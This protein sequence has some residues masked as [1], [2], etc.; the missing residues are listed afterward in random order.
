MNYQLLVLDLDGTL[1]NSRKEITEPT[2]K[3]LIDIQKAGKKVVLASGRPI[4]GIVALAKE[5]ELEQYGGYILSFNGARITKCS[6]D[7]IVYNRVLPA[8]VIRPI[9]EI[10]SGRPGLD[11]LTYEGNCILSGVAVNEYTKK[12]SAI[13]KM[14]ILSIEDFVEHLTFPVNKLLVTGEP[15]LLEEL[16]PVLHNRFHSLLNIYRS[17]PYFLE[18]M[19]RNIDKAHSLQ[20]LLSSIGLTS[21]SMI[22]CGDGYNDISMIEYAGLGVAM[23]NAQP[24]VKEQADFITKSNDEDGIL[25]VIDTFMRD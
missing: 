10:V 11:V 18:I 1:T 2:R 7:E 9:Y 19:P 16:M 8:E 3:A 20:K 4:N 24:I 25:H 15:A 13:N 21:E 22:C 5:L 6:T 12:E 23:A 14:E 17:E